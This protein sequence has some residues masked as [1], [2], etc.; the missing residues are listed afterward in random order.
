MTVHPYA[1][2]LRT[3]A[4]APVADPGVRIA[5]TIARPRRRPP[6][7]PMGS[8]AAA[9]TDPVVSWLPAG[10]RSRQRRRPPMGT[11][12]T[13]RPV[14]EP[15]PAPSLRFLPLLPLLVVVSV[16]MLPSASVASAVAALFGRPRAAP[17][18]AAPPSCPRPSTTAAAVARAAAGASGGRPFATSAPREGPFLN[19][20]VLYQSSGDAAATAARPPLPP[21]MAA[22]GTCPAPVCV[23]PLSAV[24][25]WPAAVRQ[26]QSA[27]PRGH[28][29]VSAMC[30]PGA[31]THPTAEPRRLAA[32]RSRTAFRPAA[33]AAA[34]AA[35]T[36]PQ[37]PVMFYA[38]LAGLDG[39]P[40][41]VSPV[42]P[43]TLWS[44]VV[45]GDANRSP[46]ALAVVCGVQLP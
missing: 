33:A 37:R 30:V 24:L 2:V 16:L 31:Q 14:P 38:L 32:A 34:V 13:G 19:A 27:C 18:V 5:M 25:K 41:G 21:P 9:A 42:E 3:P 8:T 22:T 44:A 10:R 1:P 36:G 15:T 7:R 26:P 28:V 23:P 17:S 11:P 45:G 35:E 4:G 20:L 12:R 43:S 40:L 46:P 29:V 6:W 39:G